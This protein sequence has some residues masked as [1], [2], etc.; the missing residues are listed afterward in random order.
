MNEQL[1]KAEDFG[2]E[3]KRGVELTEGLT[4]TRAERSELIRTYSEVIKMDVEGNG[5]VFKA[6]RLKIRDNRTKGTDVWHTKQ[7]AVF[8][9]G[10]KFVDAIK[11]A[12]NE[13]NLSMEAKLLEGEK[14]EENLEKE[15]VEKVRLE[16]TKE[17]ESIDVLEMPLGLGEMSAEAYSAILTGY[18]AIHATKIEEAKKLEAEKVENERLDKQES[19]RRIELAPYAQF[20]TG[21]ADLRLMEDAKYSELLNAVQVAKIDYDK[22]QDAIRKENEKL[23]KE[24]EAKEAQQEKERKQR[25]VEAETK[26]KEQAAKD[27]KVA[28]ANLAAQNAQQETNR[29]LQAEIDA[30][31]KAEADAK[32]KAEKEEQER[33]KAGDNGHFEQCIA[34]L[35][36][37]KI[38][39]SL[40][41][42]KGKKK[43]EG[44]NELIEKVINYINN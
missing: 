10:G 33:L 29:K 38:T 23:K 31:N 2:L 20:L 28:A 34:H 24:A 22:E 5:H 11:N 3:A 42:A 13:I 27:A 9:Y 39:T 32:E 8:L 19:T 12:D 18:K 26:R 35:K 21:N 37:A 7:K 14:H 25:E 43:A 30:K 41:S 6:L 15:R 4:V 40:K 17:L 36:T 44:I 16:R 1:I